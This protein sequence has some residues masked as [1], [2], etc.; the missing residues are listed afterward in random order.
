MGRLT[1]A[2]LRTELKIVSR[3]PEEGRMMIRGR[4]SVVVDDERGDERRSRGEEGR[5]SEANHQT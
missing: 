2:R 3:Q 1:R 5:C 4:T